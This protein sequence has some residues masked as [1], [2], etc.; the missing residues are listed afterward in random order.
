MA[1]MIGPIGMIS[2][3]CRIQRTN[4][5]TMPNF[6]LHLTMTLA[7]FA[8][9]LICAAGPPTTRP[10]EG[11][12]Q[13]VPKTHAL[14]DV[15]VVFAPGRVI[16]N[17]TIVIREGIIEQ[18]GRHIEIPAGARIWKLEGRTIYPGFVD[19][20][21]DVELQDSSV[22][23]G[24]PYWNPQVQPQRSAA[25]Q[26]KVMKDVN[27][28]LRSQG[29]TARLVV[30]KS[31]IIKGASALVSTADGR[32]AELVLY[33]D[34]ALHMRLS[35]TPNWHS[36]GY[37]NSP[38]GAVALA[39]QAMYDAQWYRKAWMAH[40]GDRS[41]PQP[42][43]NDAL[44]TLQNY[45][46]SSRL[47]IVDADNEQFLLRGDRF[48]RE[49]ALPIAFRGSGH[50][51][52]QLDA[53]RSTGRTVIVPVNFPKAPNVATPEA[54]A[55]VTVEQL[56]HWDIAP[57]N[58]ARLDNAGVP[59]AL[60]S[61]GL[62]DVDTFLERVRK[63]VTRGLSPDAALRALTMTPARLLGVSDRLGSLAAGK[64]A[65]FIVTDGDLFDDE[66]AVLET[67][68]QGRRY[69]IKKLPPVDLRGAWILKLSE[70]EKPTNQVLLELEGEPDELEGNISLY[71][72]AGSEKKSAELGN[73]AIGRE[74]FTCI[75]DAE[76]LGYQGYAQLS[77]IVADH[78]ET[79]S[80]IFFGDLIW[81]DGVR[82]SF[83]A[84]R[85]S[86]GGENES[87][88]SSDSSAVKEEAE[89]PKETAVSETETEVDAK[90][91]FAVNVP[92]GAFGRRDPPDQPPQVL[93]RGAT[94]WTCGDLGVLEN[95]S[96]LISHGKVQAIGHDLDVPPAA[97]VIPADGMHITPGIVD[98]HSHMATDGGINESAQAIT[99]EVRI[100]DFVDAR[101]IAIYRQLA[102]GV[103][104]ANVLHG[105][106]NPIG[107]Q[108]QVIK[109]RWGVLPEQL[110][111]VEAPSGIKFA[112]GENVKQ[113][114][115]GDQH[116][117]RYPQTRMGVEQIIRDAFRAAK[118]YRKHETEWRRTQ[119]G[120]PPRVD[121][122]LQALAEVLE[123]QRWIH[124]HAYRQDEM[125]ALLRTLEE[126]GVTIGTFQ[127]VLEGYKIA[128]EMVRHGAMG[129]AFSDWWAYKFEVYDAI[130]Y[131]GALMFRAGVNVSF[132]SD[133][134][135]LARHLNQEAA[136]AIK[137]GGIPPDEALKFVTFHPA[138]QL[139]IDQYVGSLEVGKH[140]DLV[141]WN[142]PPL[143]NFSR[144]EQTWIDGRKYFDREED[145]ELRKEAQRMHAALV[146]KILVL[147][148]PM[149][150]ADEQP[151]D[152]THICPREDF[153]CHPH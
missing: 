63:A 4:L 120:L 65:S 40:R 75:F 140:A 97:L 17:G 72:K 145:L 139:R 16:D 61:H 67:W 146:Q 3:G 8:V 44:E 82:V 149:L 116:T 23:A 79:S 88:D 48:A 6:R 32:V 141:L 13:N 126:F 74:R 38:M 87:D 108:N 20:Y 111:F 28:K 130:P 122:E 110:K 109:L 94:I 106:A 152:T 12:R 147:K 33:A 93:F 34:V 138:Q 46:D 58:A 91:S 2:D 60:T 90:A 7:C 18:V 83:V 86:P 52:R 81:P 125:Q 117:T 62:K 103:T 64:I 151:D 11:L 148:A 50:E 37:P 31:G 92:L 134:R 80:P 78:S 73:V 35:I 153:C 70:K 105:S 89:L 24:A 131:N 127:H 124:C 71:A 101:D 54:A 68:V 132:N 143:S 102:G 118:E 41:L 121:L 133:S 22:K 96:V 136:K 150:E 57:E 95:A 115:W 59:F 123:G 39:R 99:A 10:V 49:F 30:P 128:D 36:V 19:A 5:T 14:T 25:R 51:Y 100:G 76:A 69:D 144:C 85:S 55:N 1:V 129:S 84:Q 104:V 119:R 107:G 142:G 26:Y 47:V 98:C 77:A 21:S 29:I 45:V 9:P 135:E 112:L 56:M 113:S 27:E 137:Y 66:T 42:E 15:R 53:V 114:N 43:R